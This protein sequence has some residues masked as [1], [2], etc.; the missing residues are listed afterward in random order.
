MVEPAGSFGLRISELRGQLEEL[1]EEVATLKECLLA[2]GAVRASHLAE[3]ERRKRISKVWTEV[4]SLPELCINIATKSGLPATKN[5]S[6]VSRV[7]LSAVSHVLPA[8]LEQT[9]AQLVVVGGS[10]HLAPPTSL[11]AEDVALDRVDVLDVN[12]GSWTPLTCM[13][14]GVAGCAA[15][16]LGSCLYVIGGELGGYVLN[17]LFMFDPA[18]KE[19]WRVLASMLSRRTLCAAVAAGGLLYVTG[20][21]DN[22]GQPKGSME[23]YDPRADSWAKLSPMPTARFAC[24]STSS[25]CCMYVFGGKS[26]LQAI[27]GTAEGFSLT[28]GTWSTLPPMPTARSGCTA[29]ALAGKL[30][31]AGGEAP[32]EALVPP[33]VADHR[34]QDETLWG[35]NSA[36]PPFNVLEVFDTAHATWSAL[37]PMPTRRGGCAAA[38]VAGRLYVLGGISEH[39]AVLRD[40]ECFDPATGVWTVA[41]P[42]D[43]PRARCAA[44]GLRR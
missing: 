16:V 19:D 33:G 35:D 18:V 7:H 11:G 32:G 8:I 30:F 15:T 21:H 36:L 3:S 6:V 34:E 13:Q 41:T 1:R 24:A 12:G 4:V 17:N 42:L 25:G 28:S 29:A 10:M 37:A 5:L 40:V 44:V 27:R 22:M 23:V 43:R 31:V 26:R 9:P 20:G 39:G 2:T 38:T 14:Q